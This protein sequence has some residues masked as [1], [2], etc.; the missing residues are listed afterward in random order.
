LPQRSI[1]HPSHAMK[2]RLRHSV[3]A[4]PG[5]VQGYLVA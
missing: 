5:W 3:A 2:L 1:N 4:I